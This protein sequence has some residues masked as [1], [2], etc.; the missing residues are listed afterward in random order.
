MAASSQFSQNKRGREEYLNGVLA[1]PD[2][3]RTN[4]RTLGHDNSDLVAVIEKMDNMDN[5]EETAADLEVEVEMIFNGV[6][7]SLEDE[8]G[9]KGQRDSNFKSTHEKRSTDQMGSNKNGELTTGANSVATPV[10]S[11]IGDFSYHDDVLAGLDF[12]V[13]H[14]TPDEFGI[15]MEN[16]LDQDSVLDVM[17]SNTVQGYIDNTESYYGPLWTDDS[18]PLNEYPVIQKDFSSPRQEEFGISGAKFHD[19]WN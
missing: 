7:K 8:I 12:F 19:V 18:W 5:N 16:Y 3:K 14:I 17:Y 9:L 2:A 10:T 11:D 6:L 1:S 13:D 15:M 4:R